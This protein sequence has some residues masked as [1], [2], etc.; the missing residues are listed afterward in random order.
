MHNNTYNT[1]ILGKSTYT[2]ILTIQTSLVSLFT[3]YI[4]SNT[5]YNTNILGK[6]TYTVILAI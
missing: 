3:Q 6:S 1:N 4:H 5:Q 2:V